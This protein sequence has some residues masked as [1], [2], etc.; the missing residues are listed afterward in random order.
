M[1]F[2]CLIQLAATAPSADN[3]QPWQLSVDSKYIICEYK[4][5]AV[6]RD[7]FGPLG[8]GS[9]LA[10]GALLENFNTLR[11]KQSKTAK[12][13]IGENEWKFLL[14]LESWHIPPDETTKE[15][16]KARH[17]IRHPFRPLA[18]KPVLEA[19][20]SSSRSLLLIDRQSIN[21]LSTA[22]VNCSKTRFNNQE[23]HE[24]LFSSLRGCAL[25]QY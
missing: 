13:A 15:L 14:D 6:K 5:R 21:S 19:S 12:I 3:S 17:T 1:H 10:A 4:D 22:L 20:H 7:P 16:L 24:W 11:P 2:N 23:L 25:P 18:E 9:L 8:H